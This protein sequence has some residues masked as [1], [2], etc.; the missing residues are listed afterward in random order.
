MEKEIISAI[1]SGITA[2]IG[3]GLASFCS[4]YVIRKQNEQAQR[5]LAALHRSELIKR[6]LDAAEEI[7]SIFDATSRSG[8]ENRIIQIAKGKRFVSIKN[9]K[10]FIDKLEKT[11]NDK[12][13]IYISE[14][15]R[16]SLFSFRDYLKENYLKSEEIS[17]HIILSEEEFEDFYQKRKSL[18]LLIREETGTT[19][20]D[21]AK[22]EL[23]R[24]I[25]IK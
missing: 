6:Q 25:K 7:W 10:S 2:F 21:L 8:G 20:L 5:G 1:I 18:R 17:D 9:T 12:P 23:A 24:V 11:F 16:R 14:N 15:C 19:N 22:Q 4:F 3:A 13:G